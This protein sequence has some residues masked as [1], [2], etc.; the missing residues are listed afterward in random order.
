MKV[1]ETTIIEKLSLNRTIIG[2]RN[3]FNP[4]SIAPQLFECQIK[5]AQNH[6]Y[7]ASAS[8]T[9]CSVNNILCP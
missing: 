2:F 6:D 5:S 1:K 8:F 9:I 3:R 7:V 4:S